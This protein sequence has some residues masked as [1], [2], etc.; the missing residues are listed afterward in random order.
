MAKKATIT[1][2]PEV[3]LRYNNTDIFITIPLIT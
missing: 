3:P 2:A 1:I